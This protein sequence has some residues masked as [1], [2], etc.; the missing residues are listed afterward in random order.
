MPWL[1]SWR[2][3]RVP[4]QV[5]GDDDTSPAALAANLIGGLIVDVITRVACAIVRALIVNDFF[6][7]L[8]SYA[9]RW[10]PRRQSVP[11]TQKMQAEILQRSYNVP[12]APRVPVVW[13]LEAVREGLHRRFGARQRPGIL[14]CHLVCCRRAGEEDK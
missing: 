4:V 1:G 13:S 10:Q 2:T 6:F 14:G 8:T 3:A 7:R 11:L 12:P 5:R 9:C